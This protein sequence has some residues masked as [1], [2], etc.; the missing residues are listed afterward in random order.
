MNQNPCT[1]PVAPVPGRR[2][3]LTVA[4]RGLAAAAAVVVTLTALFYAVENWRG[5]R[6][7]RRLE[8]ELRARGEKLSVREL[9]PP[10]PPDDQNFAA[11]P[12]FK[13]LMRGWDTNA[14]GS[15]WPAN[16]RL[17]SFRL[18]DYPSGKGY[19]NDGRG[20]LAEVAHAMRKANETPQARRNPPG[21]PDYPVPAQPGA[22]ADD[23]LA[24]L[25][26]LSAGLAEIAAALERPESQFDIRWE[27]NFAALLPHLSHLKAIDRLFGVRALARLAKRDTEGAFADTMLGLQLPETLVGEPLIISQLVR[28]AMAAIAIEPLGAGIVDHQWTD[29]QL[30][31]FQARLAS[32]HYLEGFVLALEGERCLLTAGL[33]QCIAHPE[34]VRQLF[35]AE[36]H[37]KE[38]K[39]IDWAVY[40]PHG[41]LR[42]NQA[43]SVRRITAILEALRTAAAAG[44]PARNALAIG[45]SAWPPELRR[46]LDVGLYTFFAR[47]SE[48]SARETHRVVETAARAETLNALAIVACALERF[49]I[50]HGAYPETLAEL[51]PAYLGSPALDPMDGKPLRYG[52]L[53][54]GSFKLYSVGPNLKDDGGVYF[55]KDSGDL[56]WPWPAAVRHGEPTLF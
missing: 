43:A 31:E 30:A 34:M 32:R 36:E 5:D 4:L 9:L 33:E 26:P 3:P 29:R 20:N 21:R 1:P 49:R 17:R 38:A 50:A 25:E 35:D 23:V 54:D 6:A 24:G 18:P 19:T 11:T 7:W 47:V 52:R 37:S 39:Y 44:P 10:L 2:R 56:D 53:P 22:P 51:S 55:R 14:P 41:W 28:R 15:R 45:E 46:P 16:D 13:E 12:L 8:A 27:D 42:Q 48:S 40:G